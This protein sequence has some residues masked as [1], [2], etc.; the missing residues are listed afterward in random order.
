MAQ[1]LHGESSVW[2]SEYKEVCPHLSK[3]HSFCGY[4]LI[5]SAVLVAQ[6]LLCYNSRLLP[7]G[8]MQLGSVCVK[9]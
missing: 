7:L 3:W 5:R 9:I 2:D 1:V 6:A 8:A 4:L